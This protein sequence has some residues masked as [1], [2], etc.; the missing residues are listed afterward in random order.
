[1]ATSFDGNATELIARA[2]LSETERHRLL[3]DERRR[4]VLDVLAQ[5]GATVTFEALAAAVDDC[6]RARA[7]DD[8]TRDR[9]RVSL[10]HVHL[11]KL[12]AAGLLLYDPLSKRV[13]VRPAG[14]GV[15]RP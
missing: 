6:E 8:A 3:A 4:T 10:H 12:A 9:I 5:R 13:E 7:V 2:E 11:P 15:A 14:T 1:M